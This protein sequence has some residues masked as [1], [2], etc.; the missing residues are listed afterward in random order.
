LAA[1]RFAFL[2]D[3]QRQRLELSRLAGRQPQNERPNTR[4][5]P[6]PLNCLTH[7]H[8]KLV[9]S[10]SVLASRHEIE[11]SAEREVAHKVDRE[12]AKPLGD[13][14]GCSGARDKVL[15]K[16][17]KA[18]LQEWLIRLDRARGE[19]SV[20]DPTMFAVCGGV[21]ETDQRALA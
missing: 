12:K 5:C 1:F 9:E 7:P 16:L 13:V 18:V 10:I 14:Y 20:A 8:E 19:S 11:S 4:D 15:E 2:S 3:L 6:E 17:V 21:D